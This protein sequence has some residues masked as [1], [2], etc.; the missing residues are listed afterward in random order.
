MEDYKLSIYNFTFFPSVK[1][2]AVDQ[3]EVNLN[4]SM[5]LPT[6]DHLCMWRSTFTVHSL[7]ALGG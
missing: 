5:G 2:S 4:Y 7:C 6:L 3:E 1:L